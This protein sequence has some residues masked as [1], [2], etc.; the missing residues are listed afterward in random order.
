MLTMDGDAILYRERQLPVVLRVFAV[1]LGLGIATVIPLAF[2]INLRPGMSALTLLVVGAC[3][4]FPLVIGPFFILIGLV[5]A[6]ELRLDPATGRATR[7]LRGPVVNR[8]DSFALSDISVDQ[9]AMRDSEDGPFP[10][11]RLHLPGWRRWLDMA[12]FDNRAEA[13]AWRAR[14]LSTLRG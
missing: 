8:R 1:V 5:S 12:C 2:L 7:I 13:E 11:L 14:I 4:L 10:I 3:V 9:V 6:T